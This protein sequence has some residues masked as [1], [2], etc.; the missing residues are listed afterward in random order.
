MRFRK[1]IRFFTS[2]NV[3]LE[4]SLFL[5]SKMFVKLVKYNFIAKYLPILANCFV[6]PPYKTD[7]QLFTNLIIK[8]LAKSQGLLLCHLKTYNNTL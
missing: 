8:S 1:I 6:P 4:I 7:N 2:L 5:H 3:P